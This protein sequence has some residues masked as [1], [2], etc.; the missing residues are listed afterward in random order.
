[1]LQLAIAIPVPLLR[2]S[3]R[4]S[5]RMAL[6]AGSALGAL[7]ATCRPPLRHASPAPRQFWLKYLSLAATPCPVTRARLPIGAPLTPG[8][9]RAHTLMGPS[10]AWT[11]RPAANAMMAE[12]PV[13]FSRECQRTPAAGRCPKI[14]PRPSG[15][16]LPRRYYQ[17]SNVASRARPAPYNRSHSQSPLASDAPPS[18]WPVAFSAPITANPRAR[19]KGRQRA[20]LSAHLG[21]TKFGFLRRGMPQSAQPNGQKNIAVCENM[22]LARGVRSGE[23]QARCIRSGSLPARGAPSRFLRSS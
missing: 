17:R 14:T 4:I 15:Q 6:A 10:L 1:L 22:S 16:G 21:A 20:Y 2:Y 11:S 3:G 12:R 9:W 18:A 8:L 5:A 13:S 23:G 19:Q 7:K